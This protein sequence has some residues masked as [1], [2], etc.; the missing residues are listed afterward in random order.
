MLYG[1]T[2]QNQKCTSFV[3]YLTPALLHGMLDSWPVGRVELTLKVDKIDNGYYNIHMCTIY[4]KW[5]V[6][7][8]VHIVHCIC[9]HSHVQKCTERPGHTHQTHTIY[10]YMYTHTQSILVHCTFSIGYTVHVLFMHL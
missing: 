2:S 4:S 5:T 8:T 3:V 6:V 1:L 9:T 7:Y 10:M